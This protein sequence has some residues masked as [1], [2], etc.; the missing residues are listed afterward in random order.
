MF[1]ALLW[2]KQTD[3]TQDRLK[4]WELPYGSVV[5][6]DTQTKGR[7]RL[8]R[9]WFSKEGGL[10]LSFLLPPK[11]FPELLPLPLVVGL[12]TLRALEEASK[13][14]MSLKWPNDVYAQGKKIAG[15]LTELTKNKLIV[16]IG[17]NVN[18]EEFPDEIKNKTTSLRLVTKKQYEK[19]DI[20]L[21]LLSHISLTLRTLKEEGFTA[22][23]REIEEKLL[24]KGKEVK[25]AGGGEEVRGVLVGLSPRGGALILTEG[26]IREVISGEMSLREV[27][28]P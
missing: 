8:G 24:Y 22:L 1:H 9:R 5:V 20:L 13:T 16:G 15:I 23:R 27:Q 7:G 3:S 14:T 2:L 4:E 17:V 19:K 28:A 12:G 21:L 25:L 10:Y 18:Q 11:E 6:A 26:R